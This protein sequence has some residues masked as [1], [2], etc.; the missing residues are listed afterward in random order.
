MDSLRTMDS[1]ERT[2]T[3]TCSY[4]GNVVTP[5]TQA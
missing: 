5:F 4:M 1:I 2:S 3:T